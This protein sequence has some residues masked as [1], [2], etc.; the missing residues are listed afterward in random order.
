MGQGAQQLAQTNTQTTQMHCRP[1]RH[2][3]FQR[4]RLSW[5]SSKASRCAA[6]STPCRTSL[7]RQPLPATHLTAGHL[8]HS[9]AAYTR[10]HT[11]PTVGCRSA[12]L[13]TPQARLKAEAASAS[14]RLR[15]ELE[16]AAAEARM[17]SQRAELAEQLAA[18]RVEAEKE[19]SKVPYPGG[20]T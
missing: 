19:I 3:G 4:W 16:A 7:G 14:S 8:N 15:L 6:T 13:A 2:S 1:W 12:L 20:R 10:G 9:I 5:Q 18:R 11:I 17:A